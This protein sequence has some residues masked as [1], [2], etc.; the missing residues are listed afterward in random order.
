MKKTELLAALEKVKPGLANKDMIAQATSF[1]FIDGRVVT[2]NDE[3]SVSCVVPGIEV[4]GAVKADELY[5]FLSKI[6]S[7][8]FDLTIDGNEIRIKSGKAKVGLVLESE[9]R[10]PLSELGE[11]KGWKPLPEDF[12]KTVEM[13]RFCCAKNMSKPLCTCIHVEKD[14]VVEAFDNYRAIR[15]KIGKI[16]YSFLLPISAANNLVS[17]TVTQMATS[18]GWVHFADK[19][20][21]FV[22]S[23]R[24]FA[25]AFFDLTPYLQIEDGIAFTFPTESADI[26]T[27]ARVFSKTDNFSDEQVEISA[28]GKRLFFRVRTA[29]SW[30]EEWVKIKSS[31]DFKTYMHPQ[32]LQDILKLTTQCQIVP[33]R[34]IKF[35]GENWEHT[36]QLDAVK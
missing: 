31:T 6:N 3:I 5:S 11:V 18:P 34:M 30:F 2:F 32:F 19:E 23:C 13:T 25:E 29:G 27:R 21:S 7:E 22:F 16:P 28:E 15:F 10:L 8:E 4:E 24:V 14:G 1:A 12:V 33:G 17:Y 9:I 20:K 26:L 36:A 35:F